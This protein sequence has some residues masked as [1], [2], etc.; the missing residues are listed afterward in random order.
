MLAAT[1]GLLAQMAIVPPAEASGDDR[2]ARDARS[3]QQRF[4]RIRRANL[5]R[6][7]HPHWEQRPVMGS[8]VQQTMNATRLPTARAPESGPA[9]G[10]N[11]DSSRSPNINDLSVTGAIN[12]LKK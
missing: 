9:R 3:A 11:I 1:L 4:E 12:P 7:R 5:P 8:L 2:A 6:K 10:D